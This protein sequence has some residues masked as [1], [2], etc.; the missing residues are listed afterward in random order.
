MSETSV[1]RAEILRT[2]DFVGWPVTGRDGASVGTVSDILIDREGKVRFLAVDR[3]MF[4]KHVLVPVEVMEWGEGTLVAGWTDAEVRGLPPYE[5]SVALT[6][7]VLEELS[8][9]YPR[10]YR[11]AGPPPP[12]I[13]SEGP[14]IVPIKEARDFKLAKGAPNLHGWTVYGG[15]NEKVG[16]VAGM[17]V[18]PVA[19]KIRYLDVDVDDD[20]FDLRDDR[21]VL[22]PIEH[23]ELR[24][25][26]EDAWV[27]GLDSRGIA[28]LPAYTGGAADPFVE[29]EVARAFGGGPNGGTG[30]FQPAREQPVLQPSYDRAQDDRIVAYDAPPPLPPEPG[31]PPLPGEAVPSRSFDGD[32]LPPPRSSDV[33]PPLPPD[34]G[35]PPIIVDE[36]WGPDED[37]ERRRR[38]GA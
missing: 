19:M 35:K 37:D 30:L 7:G 11:T 20:L 28:A 6:S 8:R 26:N 33:P 31:P 3:G 5:P 29:D 32:T 9:A 4:R 34:A 13:P 22:V 15:D 1:P 17:L 12:P 10:Y 38:G 36:G 21:H 18:D 2:R 24:E 27:A 14:R 23:V 25:R 16:T